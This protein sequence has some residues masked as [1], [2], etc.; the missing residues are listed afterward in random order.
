MEDDPGSLSVGL[1][2]QNETLM[3][4]EAAKLVILRNEIY[5]HAAGICNSDHEHLKLGA[6]KP[7][8]PSQ[9]VNILRTKSFVAGPVAR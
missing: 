6:E 1:S 2:I 9:H 5:I 7:N 8:R 4:P 3:N